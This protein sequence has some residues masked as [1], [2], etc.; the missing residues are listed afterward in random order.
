MNRLPACTA[1]QPDI[2]F[3]FGGTNDSWLGV[4]VGEPKYSDWTE[5]DLKC[6]LPAFCKMI[7]DALEQA[8]GTEIVNIVNSELSDEVTL[9]Q[10]GVCEHYGVTCVMLHDIDKGWGHPSVEGM[11]AIHDQVIAAME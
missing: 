4:P 11:K 1:L 9:G 2:L 5:E 8:P 7:S 6:F 10:A 3:I